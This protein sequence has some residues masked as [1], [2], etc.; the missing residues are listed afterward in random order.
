MSVKF[1]PKANT[2]PCLFAT[3]TGIYPNLLVLCED[4]ENQQW[5]HASGKV[6]VDRVN[7]FIQ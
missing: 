4:K 7:L 2:L 3:L 6:V 5:R 1:K